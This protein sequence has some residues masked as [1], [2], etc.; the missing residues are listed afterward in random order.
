M[1]NNKILKILLK[2]LTLIAVVGSVL[3]F[4]VFFMEMDYAPL[5]AP[6][7]SEMI[8]TANILTYLL[9]LLMAYGLW[10]LYLFLQKNDSENLK[11]FGVILFI[12]TLLNVINNAVIS[13][14]FS[15]HLGENQ[16]NISVNIDDMTLIFVGFSLLVI[17][18]SNLLKSSKNGRV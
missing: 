5:S 8:M 11:K 3:S 12:Y 9:Q 1:L 2:T 7:P 16:R 17:Y 14:L 4:Y 15:W 6:P 18:L 10:N 13:V